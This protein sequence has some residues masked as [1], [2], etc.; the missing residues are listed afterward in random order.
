MPIL[1]KMPSKAKPSRPR[2]KQKALCGHKIVLMP[3][4]AMYALGLES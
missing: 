4:A 2:E 3:D 1:E